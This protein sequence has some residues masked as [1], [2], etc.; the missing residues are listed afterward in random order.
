M[1][2]LLYPAGLAGLLLLALAL[3]S[4]RLDW[5]PRRDTAE[6]FGLPQTFADIYQRVAPAVVSISSRRT[7][8]PPRLRAFPFFAFPQYQPPLVAQSSGS[9][10]F[11]SGDGYLLTN[12]H[13]VAGAEQVEVTLQNGRK[14]Q[15]RLVGADAQS[16]LAVLKLQGTGYPF[17]TFADRARP[18]VGDWVIA[19]GNPF[20]LGSSATAGIVSA[21]GRQIGDGGVE[22]MQLDAALNSGSSGG[23]AFDMQGRVIGVN[24][25]ILSP[26]GGF[27][28][29]GYALPAER[30]HAVAR[31][32]MAR[33]AARG[34][35]GSRAR[36]AQD[37]R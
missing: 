36:A 34:L 22:F 9:G 7:V 12:A 4:W 25:A 31:R 20:G 35:F 17:V 28:G 32:L 24:T 27:I 30:A 26:N 1:R 37:R 33:D 11:I 13:V 19:I 18:R 10:F 29:I 5:L 14:R 16:D 23:P 21:Y 2:R 8:R 3:V 15:A 6:E